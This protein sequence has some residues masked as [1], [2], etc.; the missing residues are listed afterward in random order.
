MNVTI[1]G[2]GLVGTSL[3]LALKAALGDRADTL[4]ITGHDPDGPRLKRARRLG[5]IDKSHWNLPSAC[6]QADLI[7]LDLPLAEMETTLAA[8]GEC[9]TEGCVLID[10]FSLKAPVMAMAAR[11]LPE[12]ANLVGGHLVSRKPWGTQEPGPELA[13]DAVFYL[14]AGD[15]TPPGALRA[16]SNLAEAVGARP[17]F[18]DAAEHDG[19]M[20]ASVQLPLLSALALFTALQG[21]PGSQELIHSV[22][23]ELAVLGAL[24]APS[25]MPGAAPAPALAAEALL[26][27]RDNLLQW[28]EG[29]AGAVEALRRCLAD[30]DEE[31]LRAR[32]EAGLTT[33]SAWLW[34]QSE[35][36]SAADAGTGASWRSM[37]LGDGG[38]SLRGLFGGNR[39]RQ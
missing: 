31:A 37:F 28:L 7:L 21:R 33:C 15:A 11:L 39:K 27:N 16:A 10:T 29:Y 12:T 4:S 38:A 13:Q 23:T 17:R 35:G 2:L 22:G 32:L 3:G 5:A 36:V 20:A 24:V 25:D 26:A 14:V 19:L 8:L 9:L 1:V 30:A 6:E 34:P 18:I